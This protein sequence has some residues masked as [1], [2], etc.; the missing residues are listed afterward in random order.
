MKSSAL[1][2][3]I[4]AICLALL[5]MP[6][7]AQATR[8]WVSGVG[9]DASPCSRTAP[10][11]TFAGAISKTAA[12]GEINCLDPGGFGALNI[13]K[14]IAIICDYTEGG[15]LVGGTNGFSVN[16]GPNDVVYLSGPDFEGVGI[17]LVGIQFNTGAALHVINSRIRGFNSGAATGIS[18]N[19]SGTSELYVANSFISENGTGTTGGG[20]FVKPSGT[21]SIARAIISRTNVENNALGIRADGGTSTTAGGVAVTVVDS[22]V[23]GNTDAGL[24]SYAQ[25]GTASTI[26]VVNR[27]TVAHNGTGVNANGS[28]A[29]M[30]IGYSVITGNTTGVVIANSAIMNSY[31]TNQISDNN[32]PGP[33]IPTIPLQ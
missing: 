7:N 19:P 33:T 29:A 25:T 9:D 27:T 1:L 31:Q 14:A 32:T 28:I 8:T 24:V 17:G 3:L 18:F 26:V 4:G 5:S 30:R 22:V 21:G 10:C 23:V 20:I 6:A 15:V 16:A 11:K 13:T 2:A 12:N